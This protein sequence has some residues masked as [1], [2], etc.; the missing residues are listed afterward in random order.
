AI[1]EGYHACDNP[2][3]LCPRCSL[4]GMTGSGSGDEHGGY[5]GRFKASTLI[6][7]INLH[8]DK[9]TV[10]IPIDT[11]DKKEK[12]VII[13]HLDG[14]NNLICK[15]Y[16]LPIQGQPKPNK[17]DV[18]GYFDKNTGH[19]KGAKYY[20]HAKCDI[21]E[22][23]NETNAMKKMPGSDL[24][25]THKLRNFAQVLTARE[26]FTGTVGA[27][28]CTLDEIS[29]LI[30]ILD[31]H[32]AKYGF[33]IGIG[34]SF[35]M[36]SMMSVIKKIWIRGKDYEWKCYESLEVFLQAHQEIKT[37]IENF[38]KVIET[39]QMLESQDDKFTTPNVKLQ[40]PMPV[41]EVGGRN[42]YYWQ[43]VNG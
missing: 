28:N 29:A 21:N 42:K 23:V 2:K 41:Q 26:T 11:T 13:K 17:R 27:E 14:K 3:S 39:I 16:L 32:I 9:E 15:Q 19:I 18:S 7:Q 30:T 22:L 25:Y 5:K 10:Q 24:E 35:G 1:P 37:N 4:F 36:G 8:T 12:V 33:K 38:K 20:R 43:I 6:G 31:S 40:Y 34:K